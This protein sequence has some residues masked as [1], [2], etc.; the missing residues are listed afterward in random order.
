MLKKKLKYD[1]VWTQHIIYHTPTN[2]TPF[3]VYF[4]YRAFRT[5]CV[6][7]L[8]N[9]VKHIKMKCVESKQDKTLLIILIIINYL[10]HLE[11]VFYRKINRKFSLILKRYLVLTR[12]FHKIKISLLI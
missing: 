5:L 12:F 2:T 10:L 8:V 9:N 11:P 1:Y 3:T 7:L 6:I 4:I